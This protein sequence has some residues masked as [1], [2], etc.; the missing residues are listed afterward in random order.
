[1]TEMIITSCLRGED[2]RGGPA[3]ACGV[4]RR[5]VG[6]AREHALGCA[7][8]RTGSSSPEDRRVHAV[9]VT[10]DGGTC[11]GGWDVGRTG[12]GMWAA[13]RGARARGHGD[14]D[15]GRQRSARS[16]DSR[17]S[18]RRGACHA[19]GLDR[20][21][22]TAARHGRGDRHVGC[23]DPSSRPARLDEKRSLEP[24]RPLRRA[25]RS[26][27][28]R[29][30]P[31]RS[32]RC[33]RGRG[34]TARAPRPTGITALWS[35]NSATPGSRKPT[36]SPRTAHRSATTGSS[37]RATSATCLTC[38]SA[39]GSWARASRCASWYSSQMAKVT[40]HDACRRTRDPAAVGR[41]CQ[42]AAPPSTSFCVPG[43]SE[44]R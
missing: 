44:P 42:P 30:A 11:G 15:L 25:Y 8:R 35:P 3:P 1:M 4:P 38:I 32:I 7:L 10:K 16:R 24:L 27:R 36:S 26:G 40:S 31:R 13:D 28:G 12:G 41:P 5:S 21:R 18:T 20:R 2:S 34:A 37:S 9:V 29:S 43:G 39:P 23:G 33:P 6:F 19:V 14:P 17:A 22:A